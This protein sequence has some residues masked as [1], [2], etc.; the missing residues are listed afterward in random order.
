MALALS[1]GRRAVVRPAAAGLD[2]AR[3]P[4]LGRL[5]AGAAVDAPRVRRD[6]RH[7]RAALRRPGH[8]RLRKPLLPPQA[9]AAGAGRR[10]HRAVPHHHR[11]AA[12]RVG[13]RGPTA[14]RGRGSPAACRWRCGS[15]SSP[16]AESWPTTCK[17]RTF[18]EALGN[19]SLIGR[20]RPDA[21]Q[22]ARLGPGHRRHQRHRPRPERRRA[23]G[24]HDHG[25][26]HRH[27]CDSHDRLERIGRLLAAQP[28]ARFLPARGNAAGLQHLHA[29]RH[30]AA[31]EQQPGDQP[32]RSASARCPSRCR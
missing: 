21:D 10:Q 13:Y 18:D 1:V 6:V 14:R 4:R 5:P 11:P 17:R 2:D 29:D 12:R 3:R 30:R 26:A 28:A 23:A 16:W 31:G 27:G 15:G 19:C 20:A 7:R 24:R 8:R 25:D 9:R 22:H 32:G